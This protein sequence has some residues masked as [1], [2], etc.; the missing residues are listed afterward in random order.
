MIYDTECGK[1]AYIPPSLKIFE[2]VTK[3]QIGQ[4]VTA[5]PIL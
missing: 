3:T 5:C 2:A 4:A 1:R